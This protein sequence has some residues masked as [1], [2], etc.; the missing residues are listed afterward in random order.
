MIINEIKKRNFSKILEI[1]S[2]TGVF[3]EFFCKAGF[4]VY[5]I[6]ISLDLLKKAQIKHSS[7]ISLRLSVADVENLPYA[8]NSFDAVVG[9]CVLHHLDAKKAFKEIRRVLKEG[10]II[11]FSEPNMMNPQL[12]IQKNVKSI[13]RISILGETENETAFFKWK[14]KALLKRM[15]FKEINITPFDF[16]HPWTPPPLIPFIKRLGYYCESTPLLR[17]IAGSLFILAAK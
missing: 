3:T 14:L 17:D 15:H 7:S 9:I 2:G 12:F 10:G 11:L 8:D 4:D 6:D 16:L 5:G 13:K 1:G